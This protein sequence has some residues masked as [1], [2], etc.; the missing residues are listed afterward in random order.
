MNHDS[1]DLNNFLESLDQEYE[2]HQVELE[3]ELEKE[4]DLFGTYK[5]QE[6]TEQPIEQNNQIGTNIDREL[7]LWGMSSLDFSFMDRDSFR[8]NG[9]RNGNKINE[10]LNQRHDYPKVLPFQRDISA[11]QIRPQRSKDLEETFDNKQNNRNQ[12]QR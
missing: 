3:Q 9:T 5:Q 7:D 8:A 10:R 4:K 2:T 1:K 11:F 6:Q 12:K